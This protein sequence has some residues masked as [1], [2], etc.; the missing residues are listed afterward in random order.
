MRLI[1]FILGLAAIFMLA[2]P[3]WARVVTEPV[4]TPTQNFVLEKI[5]LDAV[6]DG[7]KARCTLKYVI[8]NPSDRDIEVDFL[9]PLPAGG[10]VTGLTLFDGKQEMPGKVYNKDEA[11]NIYREIVASLKDPALLE[12]AGRDTF[13]ARIFPVPAKGR[14]TLELSFDFLVPKDNGQ[15]AFSFPIAGPMTLGKNPEQDIHVVVKDHKG[16]SGIYTP[17]AG[18]DVK[19]T[20]GQDAVI[21]FTETNTAPVE[22]FRLYFQTDSGPLGGLVLSHKPEKD[23][24][25]FFLFLADPALSPKEQLE[26]AKNVIFVLDKSGS[27]SGPKFKQACEALHFILDRLDNNDKFNLVDYNAKVYTW[28]KE[29]MDMSNANRKSAGAYVDN[30]RSGGNTNIEDA[31]KTAFKLVGDSSEPNYVIFLTDGQPT[32]GEW[33]EL[34]LAEIAKKANPGGVRLFSFGVGYD[35]NARLLDR[36][37]G[38]AGGTSV[39]V[40]P[41]ENLETK[42]S[43]FFSKI[44]TPALTRPALTSSRNLNRVLP[45]ELPDV[46]TG[47]QLVVVGRYAQGGETTFTLKGRQGNKEE[48]FTYKVNLADGPSLDGDF[49]ASLW[50]Q[51]RIGELLDQ[52]DLSGSKPSK[53]LI[54]ELVQLSKK[55]GILTPYTSFL[56]LEDQAIYSDE[57]LAPVVAQNLT[58]MEQ[59]VG[60]SANK[61]REIKGDMKFAA[62]PQAALPKEQAV[63]KVMEMAEMDMAYA[64]SSSK[65]M[66]LPNQW[67]GQTFFFKSGQWQ[68]ENLTEKDLKNVTNIKQLSDEYYALAK[69]LKPNEMIWMTQKEPVVFNHNGVTYLIEPADD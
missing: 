2:T 39:F 36:L 11:W 10:T 25:G 57:E 4:V 65:D 24:D 1:K 67:A 66:S 55:Y 50:A 54:D 51:R 8:Y 12:Y 64:K 20:P 38:Q 35:V 26:A 60:S 56:A 27:M 43:E 61:Q 16:L 14:Q 52:I 62:A 30:L 17:V 22:H 23:E 29:L 18:A 3:A 53:E 45:E 47:Q 15:V 34:K 68:A 31:L 13:R 42:V 5:T 69:E 6:I 33:D 48:T 41:E 46:F 40:S 37:S 58:A 9:A 63:S 32:E 28:Q 44:T 7:Q 59:T 19:H 21:T 49:I